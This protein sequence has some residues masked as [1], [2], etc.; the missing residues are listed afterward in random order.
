MIGNHSAGNP[1][2]E[3]GRGPFR[4]A[5]ALAEVLLPLVPLAIFA[6]L[7][8]LVLPV[9]EGE[10]FTAAWGWV[11]S[12]EVD[13]SFHV[14]GLG[15]LF[16]LLIS[17]IGVLIFAYAPG[18]LGRHP[19]RFRLYVWLLLFMGSMLGLV[20]AN[21][22]IMLFV[23][24]E[25]TSITSYML[26]GFQHDSEKARAAAW[27]ALL[28]TGLGGLALLAGLVLLGHAGGSYELTS[29][30]NEGER[31]REHPLLLPIVLLIL[32]GAFTKSAQFPFH[33]WLPAAME[34]PTPVS[35]YLH[36]ATMVKAG[37]YLVARLTPAFSG[38]VFWDTSVAVIGTLTALTGAALALQQSDLK[39]ILAYSTV[40]ALGT[41][42]LL[43]A[44]ATPLALKGAVV[45]LLCHCL[46]KGGLFLVAGAV[47]H[48]AGSRNVHQL[49][50]LFGTLPV[51]AVA[52]CLTGLSMAGLPPAGGFLAKELVYDAS[53]KLSGG[54]Q[55]ILAAM[56]VVG[57][58]FVAV[59]CLVVVRPFFGP[60]SS[61]AQ[62]VHGAGWRLAFPPL[63][64]GLIGLAIGLL[65][66]FFGDYVVGP[67]V[68]AVQGDA[69]AVTLKLWHGFNLPLLLSVVTVIA[70]GALY[71]QLP[72][73][74]A[75]GAR[76]Q[77]LVAWGPAAC[78]EWS[79]RAL[80]T[81]AYWQTRILQDGRLRVYLMTVL[82]TFIG[83]V[84][85]ELVHHIRFPTGGPSFEVQLYELIIPVLILCATVMALRSASRL[86]AVCALGV[87]GYAMAMLFVMFGAPDLAMTQLAIETLTVILFVFVIYRLPRFTAFSGAGSR[88][89]DAVLATCAGG[90]MT[91]VVWAAT[92]AH[93][94]SRVSQ[95]FADNSLTAAKGKNMVNVILVDFRG[96]DTLGEITVLAVAALG[97]LALMRLRSAETAGA[98][99]SGAGEQPT[100]ASPA[101]TST[102][103]VTGPQHALPDADAPGIRS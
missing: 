63:L 44:I 88:V 90:V 62:S 17:G 74:Q 73:L 93:A 55:L 100:G 61:P 5:A 64:A 1:A 21:N 85:F 18:Y 45:F 47:D 6:A 83:L 7:A 95:Y 58:A 40:S 97:I 80:Q 38:V 10:T 14:D 77:P 53:L 60:R 92:L 76:L 4:L 49:G 8:R 103:A 91:A 52:A 36:S 12:L 56:F 99:P 13:L 54:A 37:V 42:M 50:G 59:A 96:L 89:R 11:P 94:P 51:L 19:D 22:I 75:V 71:F 30:L 43:F 68:A 48:C 79:L 25:L 20:L 2:D 67:A 23:F 84:G 41:L 3:A 31:V 16:A 78:Y 32:L 69:K 24:W 34:A 46:Y 86:A 39:R 57:M 82:L 102:A 28:V 98:S 26:I 29:L 35:A 15:L 70:G 27:Q 81:I 66:G 72:R 87:I 33:F 101:E 9:S 65:P